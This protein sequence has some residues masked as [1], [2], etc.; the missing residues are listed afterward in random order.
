MLEWKEGIIQDDTTFQCEGSDRDD[1]D[2]DETLSECQTRVA[3]NYLPRYS[4][5]KMCTARSACNKL[6][7]Y[8]EDEY[9]IYHQP[10]CQTGAH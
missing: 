1:D 7:K 3:E 2:D 9:T 6:V 4:A 10:F 5:G 8:D